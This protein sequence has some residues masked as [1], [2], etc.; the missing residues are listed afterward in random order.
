MCTDIYLPP[1]L[2]ILI[3]C[4]PNKEDGILSVKNVF[5]IVE[6]LDVISTLTVIQSY[7]VT[8]VVNA[9]RL[10]GDKY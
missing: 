9:I 3:I 4:C 10:F 8:P 2:L 6:G 7:C 1:P 5:V